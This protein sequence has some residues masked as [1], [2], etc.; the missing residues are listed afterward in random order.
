ML[1]AKILKTFSAFQKLKEE[2]DLPSLLSNITLDKR[3][4]TLEP[5]EAEELL[6]R[7]PFITMEYW[8]SEL[9]MY[10]T[11]RSVQRISGSIARL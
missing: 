6:D 8:H 4:V 5:D 10:S 1:D 9:N 7:Q 11:V 3:L 2:P